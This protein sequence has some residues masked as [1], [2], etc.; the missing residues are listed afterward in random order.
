MENSKPAP[1][2]TATHGETAK[3]KR[4]DKTDSGF[5]VTLE[6]SSGFFIQHRDLAWSQRDIE[7]KVG[8]E[9][10]VYAYLGSRIRGFDLNGERLFYRTDRELELEQ[11]LYVERHKR[12][13]A[14]AF[15]REQPQLDADYEALPDVFKARIDRRRENNP[16]FRE[17]FESYEMF[18]CKQAVT[19]AE[20]AREE[21]RRGQWTTEIDEF[22]SNDLTG[23][24]LAY[25]PST[26]PSSEQPPNEPELRALYWW[27]ALNSKAYDYDYKR[28]YEVMPGYDEGHSGNTHG[29]AVL[30][31]RLYLTEPQS[32]PDVAGALSPIVGS[33]EYGD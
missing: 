22:W 11:E 6:N 5:E 24:K 27:N 32:V 14:E 21:A 18:V 13:K 20:W 29:A 30:L 9:I 4:V 16:S 25:P 7:I 28:C 33:A 23:W 19:M 17:E 26:Y 12:E 2:D 8:D 10:T 3:V 31:A 15:A 1:L